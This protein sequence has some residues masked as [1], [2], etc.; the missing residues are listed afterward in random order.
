M[1]SLMNAMPIMRMLRIL[2]G[3]GRQGPGHEFRRLSRASHVH[4]S[5]QAPL[6][7][8]KRNNNYN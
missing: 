5:V 1:Q 4:H 6:L 8:H 7:Y 3:N 2:D